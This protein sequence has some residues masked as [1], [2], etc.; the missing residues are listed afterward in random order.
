MGFLLS[1]STQGR[2]PSVPLLPPSQIDEV[3]LPSPAGSWEGGG[4]EGRKA[5]HEQAAAQRIPFPAPGT[6]NLENPL[7]LKELQSLTPEQ[8]R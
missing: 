8:S 2:A 5:E 1:E 3:R 6:E 7:K 4:R